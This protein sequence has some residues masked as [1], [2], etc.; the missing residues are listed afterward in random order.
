MCFI[1]LD[2]NRKHLSVAIGVLELSCVS[3]CRHKSFWTVC[4]LESKLELCFISLDESRFEAFG[5]SLPPSM[6][7]SSRPQSPGQPFPDGS[8]ISTHIPNL[9]TVPMLIDC[10]PLSTEEQ[11]SQVYDSVDIRFLLSMCFAKS[12]PASEYLYCTIKFYM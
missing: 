6:K 4:W 5:W 11:V 9:R 3:I 12:S 8:T 2:N 7:P 10:S 1:I